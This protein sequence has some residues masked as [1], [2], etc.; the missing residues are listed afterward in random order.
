MKKFL[1]FL[2]FFVT[3]YSN[4]LNITPQN[5]YYTQAN[6]N[7]AYIELLAYKETDTMISLINYL[8]NNSKFKQIELEETK[9]KVST[10]TLLQQLK[11]FMQGWPK[12][13][14]T[15]FD[16]NSD[17]AGI[18]KI[19]KDTI[20][21]DS[22]FLNI[23]QNITNDMQKSISNLEFFKIANKIKNENNI[24]DIIKDFN[25]LLNSY[26]STLSKI[27][28]PLLVDFNPKIKDE[29][30]KDYR[31]YA[32]TTLIKTMQIFRDLID[33]NYKAI[34]NGL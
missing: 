18:E 16:N 24:Q 12:Y 2:S 23:P 6:L 15:Y 3:L 33:K 1:I 30:E 21:N 25:L 27:N 13:T 22:N 26:V 11:Y 4:N 14:N 19:L 9:V 32:K 10:L 28:T 17:L 20:D 29:L 34:S 31:I 8:L 7:K 5:S